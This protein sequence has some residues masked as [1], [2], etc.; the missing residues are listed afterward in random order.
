MLFVFVT[1]LLLL[2]DASAVTLKHE[3]GKEKYSGVVKEH[4]FGSSY[5][6]NSVISYKGEWEDGN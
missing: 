3:N 5:F 6:K 2:L 1:L 4:G